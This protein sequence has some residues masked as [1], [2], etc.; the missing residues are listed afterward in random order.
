[1]LKTEALLLLFSSICTNQAL[2]H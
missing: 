1:M 2:H